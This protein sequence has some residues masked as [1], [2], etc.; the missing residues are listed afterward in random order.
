MC[1]GVVKGCRIPATVSFRPGV[2]TCASAHHKLGEKDATRKKCFLLRLEHPEKE[3]EADDSDRC[4]AR[5]NEDSP[6]RP[7]NQQSESDA[8][9]MQQPGGDDKSHRIG[10]CICGGGK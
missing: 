1:A 9:E 5:A 2:G 7:A 8:A 3:A 10:Y 4:A 6:P